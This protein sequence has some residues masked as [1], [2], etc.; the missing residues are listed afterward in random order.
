MDKL[1]DDLEETG[2]YFEL[3]MATPDGTLYRA[4]FGRDYGPVVRQYTE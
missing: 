1:L 3:K 2:G 4:R